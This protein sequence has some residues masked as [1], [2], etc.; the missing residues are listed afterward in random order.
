[1]AKREK[2]ALMSHEER[3]ALI[4]AP[5]KSVAVHGTSTPWGGVFI[6]DAIPTDGRRVWKETP[7]DE[8][9]MRNKWEEK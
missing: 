7:E 1:M 9:W 2:P 8:E 4:R 3:R 5:F 6:R